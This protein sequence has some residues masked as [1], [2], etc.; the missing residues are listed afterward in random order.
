MD[1][2]TLGGWRLRCDPEATRALGGA[3]PAAA[4]AC[5]CPACEN[6][7]AQ[8]GEALDTGLRADLEGLGIDPD[9]ESEL[10]HLGRRED[11]LHRYVCRFGFV[12]AVVGEPEEPPGEGGWRAGPRAEGVEGGGEA[13]LEVEV[14][15][16]W[17][18]DLGEL[19]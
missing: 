12:G 6:Y 2:R 19:P 10:C 17:R 8:R 7:V 1:E 18:L 9:R 11:G 16:P 4:D 5:G 13:W 15:L 14:A 3:A